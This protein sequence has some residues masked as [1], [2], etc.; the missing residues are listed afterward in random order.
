MTDASNDP[1]SG[2]LCEWPALPFAIDALEPHMS[3][4]T[5]EFHHGK[6]HRAY[7]E[8]ANRL[9]VGSGFEGLQLEE[10]VRRA[11]GPLFENAAQA[12]NHSFFW[13][14]LSPRA[15][16]LKEGELLRAIEASF[17]TLEKLQAD[18]SEK[19]EE[20]FGSGWVWLAKERS[21]KLS[22][23]AMPNACNPLVGGDVPLLTCDVWE[24]AYYLDCRN[25][26]KDFL[27]RF[28]KVANWDFA[29]S[30]FEEATT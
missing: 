4:Q 1:S 23:S 7:V 28:W 8:K 29:R 26:R 27:D 10:V 17:G 14:C 15:I 13:N 30:R 19:A 21:G 16:S 9:I 12:W 11:E 3:A 5:L 18:F 22:V 24:H 2:P 25:S 20:H 6:H